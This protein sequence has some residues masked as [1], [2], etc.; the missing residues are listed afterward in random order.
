[1]S[2]LPGWLHWSLSSVASPHRPLSGGLVA[3]HILSSLPW[4]RPFWFRRHIFSSLVS[5]LLS[6]RAQISIMFSSLRVRIAPGSRR[7]PI[8]VCQMKWNEKMNFTMVYILS[9]AQNI[10]ILLILYLLQYAMM[11]ISQLIWKYSH[12]FYFFIES[13]FTTCIHNFSESVENSESPHFPQTL[14]GCLHYFTDLMKSFLVP[15]Q[16]K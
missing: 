8:N 16:P 9:N 4:N 7:S 14:H 2:F 10:K 12:K 3:P 6:D 15:L 1:M 13:H 5:D 11:I